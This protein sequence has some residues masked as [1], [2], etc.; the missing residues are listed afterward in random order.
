MCRKFY[1]P[2]MRSASFLLLLVSVIATTSSAQSDYGFNVVS[3]TTFGV[4][5]SLPDHT[6][7][8]VYVECANSTD[9]VKR[10]YADADYPGSLTAP[11][12]FYNTSA[13]YGPFPTAIDNDFPGSFPGET[14]DSWISIGLIEAANIQDNEAATQT[15]LGNPFD[16][17]GTWAEPFTPASSGTHSDPVAWVADDE[18][19]AMEWFLTGPSATTANYPSNGFAGDDGKVIV[20]QATSE[21][22]FQFTLTAEIYINGDPNEIVTVTQT[23]DGTNEDP[24]I[25]EGCTDPTACNF[26]DLATSDNGSCAYPSVNYRDCDEECINDADSDGICDEEEVVACNDPAA[27]NY[28]E[29]WTETASCTYPTGCETCSGETDGTGTVI[30]NDSDDDGVCDA[31]EV[32]GCQDESAC[33]YNEAATDDDADSCTYVDGICESCSGEI[34]GTGTVVDNDSDDDGVC[35]DDEISGCQDPTACNYNVDATDDGENCIYATGCETCSGET[36]GTGTPLDGDADND[37]V[38]DV[39][40]IEGCQNATACNYS[41][42][43]TDDD[44]SCEFCSCGALTGLS[45]YSLTVEP[46]VEDGIEGMTT[47]RI[48]ANV[49]SPLD[50]VTSIFTLEN[51]VYPF[52]LSSTSTPNWYNYDDGFGT[53]YDNGASI[54]PAFFGVFPDLEFDSW[55]T[56]GVANS[57]EATGLSYFTV[58]ADDAWASFNAGEDVA[59]SSETGG[60]LVGLSLGCSRNPDDPA[61]CDPSHPAMGG[62]DQRVLLGQ[63]TTNGTLS[64]S[65]AIQILEDGE[66]TPGV[67]RTAYFE[68]SGDGSFSEDG[69]SGP[70]SSEYQNCGCM[71]ASAFNYDADALYPDDS[72]EAV[73]EGCLDDAACNFDEAANTSDG[74]CI[75]ADD[76]CEICSDGDSVLQDADNDGVCDGDELLGCTD[77]TACNYDDDPTTDTDNSL[78]I[79][80]D[81]PCEICEAGGVTLLDDD[82]D[83][84][85]NADEIDGCTNATACNYDPTATDE[86]GTCIYADGNCEICDG[87]GG[88]S[89]QDVDDDGVCDGDEIPGC[90]AALACNFEALATD[91]NGSCVF[92]DDDCEICN[93]GA[94]LLQDADGD[95][96]CDGDEIAGCQDQTACNY[97]SVATDSDDSCV[98]ADGNCEVCDGAGGVAVLDEDGDGVCDGDEI[99]GCQDQTACNYNSEATD[100]DDSCVYADGNCEVC[101]GDGGIA[102]QDE[103]GDGVCDA[104]EIAGCQ[105]QTACNYNSEATDSDDSCVFAIANCE[106]CDGV[107]GTS[108]LDDDE[109]GVC[110]GDELAGCQDQT[111]CNYNAA[112][113]DPDTCLYATGCDYCFDP[114]SDD[115]TGTVVD[116]DADDDGVCDADEIL[117]CTDPD[118]CNYDATPTTDTDN[119]LC[120]YPGYCDS[121]SGET[122]GT[123]VVV[124]GDEDGDGV[125]NEDEILGCTIGIACN[126]DALATENQFFLCEFAD[127]TSCEYCSGETDGTGYIISGDVDNDGVCDDDEIFGCTDSTSCN[128][129]CD[130]TEDDGSCIYP[131]WG[132]DCNGNCIADSDGDGVC[133]ANEVSG[134]SDEL[135]CNYVADATDEATCFYA[136]PGFNCQGECL[137]DADE[138]GICDVNEVSGCSDELACNYVPDATDEATCFYAAPGFNC[139]GE[140]LSDADEDGVCDDYEV[141]GC[142]DPEAAN[143]NADAT[144]EDGS[145]EDQTVEEAYNAGYEAG[146][147]QGFLEGDL[148]CTGSDYCGDGT[149]WSETLGICVP[150]SCLG[151]LDASGVI[152]TSDLLIF[153]NVF[154]QPCE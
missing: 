130:A 139:Q 15:N 150:E 13:L 2:W 120:E 41:A 37:G 136:A 67:Y 135:A 6:T 30:D 94:V 127:D 77:A 88:I 131:N 121:C 138:D 73:A 106:V 51:N 32:V 86:D 24:A 47:Y 129:E 87:E 3:F 112:A 148:N 60:M 81:D 31:D 52:S 105:D 149:I 103:D 21:G 16:W 122:D 71:D 119:S 108:I 68:F 78:C 40:E 99:V 58:G 109:D 110:N 7:Y 44:G 42:A 53:T 104:D 45:D 123:G 96:I 43:A 141:N 57:V 89:V 8:Q 62:D 152:G 133:D 20:M 154:G 102:V 85:C 65:L 151:D 146:Y 38:C 101:D 25:I 79:Y 126:Y 35:N 64:G 111:A 5:I 23:F 95:G 66:Y 90:T 137:S 100:S 144:E 72:C 153:L 76:P 49:T 134:C 114:T 143:Y 125:C 80:A 14:V 83:G 54:N 48:Y 116:G 145:C 118:A 147:N 115:G 132:E 36:D 63:I 19:S 29:N 27:C 34:D 113:T 17:S 117:G 74:S 39:D 98:F 124:D 18:D 9:F 56:I 22:L 92:A 97:D 59:F 55:L 82:G 93:E 50:F 84:V 4:G 140:C 26:Y 33:N 91:D 46:Y 12:G 1:T 128:F 10:V 107:G 142:T 75:Y 28:N 61:P 69:Y 70:M 11:N